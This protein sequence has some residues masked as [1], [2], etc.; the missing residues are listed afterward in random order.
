MPKITRR[1]ITTVSR[2]LAFVVIFLVAFLSPVDKSWAL[3][4]AKTN[5]PAATKI[6][7]E[8]AFS[9]RKEHQKEKV[10]A[11]KVFPKRASI[12]A[13]IPVPPVSFQPRVLVLQIPRLV[14]F[15]AAPKQIISLDTARLSGVRFISR[16]FLF[17]IQPNAP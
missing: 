10:T 17:T 9:F 11:V 1:N 13:T 3:V 5:Q 4:Y 6:L 16:I 7:N 15:F 8:S 14:Y 12:E 2:H